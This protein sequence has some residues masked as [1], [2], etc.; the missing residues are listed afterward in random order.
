MLA[1][2]LA[3]ASS[4]G[5]GSADFLGG[6]SAKR[7]PI[8]V[9]AAVS[10]AVGLAFTLLV[11]LAVHRGPGDVSVLW[12]GAIGGVL[13]AGGLSALYQGLAVGRMGVVAPIAALSGVVPVVVGLVAQGDRPD[14]VQVVGMVLAIG[15]VV[16]A[17]RARDEVAP[18]RRLATGAGLALL[19]ALLLG[20]MVVALDAGGDRD[21]VWTVFMVR[22]SSVALLW[23][24]VAAR[25]P[26]FETVRPNLATLVGAGLLD[27]LANLLFVLAA[28]RGLLSLVSVLGSLYPVVTVVLARVVLD[29]RLARWQLVGVA[30]A[31][32][33]VALISLG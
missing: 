14:A 4:T 2:V 16:M 22:V 15:G 3:L 12:I 6:L 24:V 27:N 13:G 11:V 7:V 33:G 21:P 28:A 23:M 20:A 5:W 32:T 17:S 18:G 29:E 19:A 10:Q 25:R 26:S 31:L 30:A 1:M 9:V 8:V